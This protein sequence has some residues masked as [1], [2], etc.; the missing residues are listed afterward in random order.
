MLFRSQALYEAM[1]SLLLKAPQRPV[2]TPPV[3]VSPCASVTEANPPH[4][5]SAPSLPSPIDLDTLLKRC[6][7]KAHLAES[8]LT[9]FQAAIGPQLQE[10]RAGLD[11]LDAPAMSRLAH[12]IRGASANLS[13]DAISA[14]AA[15]LEKLGA[16]GDRDLIA[17]SLTQLEERIRECLDYLPTATSSVRQRSTITV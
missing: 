10:L 8:L 4:A 11:Q 1:D 15:Q 13:A 9:K 12:T 14:A 7:G 5:S 17:Q 6:R 3:E 2:A 16:T